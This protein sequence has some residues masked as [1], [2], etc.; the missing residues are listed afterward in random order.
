M[1][2]LSVILI[3]K[4]FSLRLTLNKI[5]FA[6]L[7]FSSLNS[8]EKSFNSVVINGDATTVKSYN[9]L[10]KNGQLADVLITDPPYCKCPFNC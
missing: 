7:S 6:T 10:L 1:F 5:R 2:M 3:P 8:N 4:L 9:S